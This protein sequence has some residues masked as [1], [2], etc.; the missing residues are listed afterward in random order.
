MA[1][2]AQKKSTTNSGNQLGSASLVI[3]NLLSETTETSDTALIRYALD[4]GDRNGLKNVLRA[5]PIVV[6]GLL[7]PRCPRYLFAPKNRRRVAEKNQA[8]EGLNLNFFRLA[9]FVG[10]DN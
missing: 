1:T 6:Y 10:G 5:Y 4:G 8:H 2:I 3:L 9:F 7:P